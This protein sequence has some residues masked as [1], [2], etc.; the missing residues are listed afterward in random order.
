M[1]RLMLGTVGGVMGSV[2]KLSCKIIGIRCLCHC[3][4][5]F[6]SCVILPVALCLGSA[7]SSIC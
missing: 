3:S 2:E 7:S 6:S 5:W 4:V 1:A